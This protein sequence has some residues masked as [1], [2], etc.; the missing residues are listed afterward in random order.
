MKNLRKCFACTMLVFII[1]VVPT[2]TSNHFT[3]GAQEKNVIEDYDPLVD[4]NITV[5]IEAIRALDT[6][7]FLSKPD[8]FVIIRINDVE[9]TSPIWENTSYLY[10]CFSVTTDVPDDKKQ[11]M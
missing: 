4:V 1:S 6:I 9:Y 10:N 8:F 7:D 3:T 11:W 2:T 5:N